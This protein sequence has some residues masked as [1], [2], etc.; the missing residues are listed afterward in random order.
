MSAEAVRENYRRQGEAR[1]R[2]RIINILQEEKGAVPAGWDYLDWIIA[3]IKD[4]SK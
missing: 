2:E 3:L 1:E 4:E